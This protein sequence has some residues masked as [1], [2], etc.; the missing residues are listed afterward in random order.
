M[1]C[2]R[3]IQTQLGIVDASLKYNVVSRKALFTTGIVQLEKVQ[4]SSSL[5]LWHS[6]L[7]CN[8]LEY[9]SG[10]SSHLGFSRRQGPHSRFT[11]FFSGQVR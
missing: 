3:E 5:Y 8:E 7:L 2:E 6:V 4:G 11:V 10:S 9:I 1:K